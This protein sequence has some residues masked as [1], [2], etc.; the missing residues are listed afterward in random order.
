MKWHGCGTLQLDFKV[1][2]TRLGMGLRNPGQ[3]RAEGAAGAGS[4]P[5]ESFTA[6]RSRWLAAQVRFRRL[7]A[8]VP[9]QELGL[10]QLFARSFLR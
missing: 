10:L 8:N 7:H 6:F 4:I 2:Q 1:P 5:I 9:E 3:G